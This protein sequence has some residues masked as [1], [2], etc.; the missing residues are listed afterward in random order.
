LHDQVYRRHFGRGQAV[1]A[2]GACAASWASVRILILLDQT[3][4]DVIVPDTSDQISLTLSPSL[5][6]AEFAGADISSID[7]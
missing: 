5:Q 2:P 1:L 6:Y 3:S 7:G 4:N